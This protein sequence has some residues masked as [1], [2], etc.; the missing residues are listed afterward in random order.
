M[1]KRRTLIVVILVVMAL[2]VVGWG[3]THWRQRSPEREALVLYGSADI[4]EVQLAFRVSDRIADLRVEEGDTVHPGQTLATL[5]TSILQEEV[6]SAKASAE[7]QRQ[8]V[9]RLVH[10]SR[11]QEIDRA[12]GLVEETR[13]ILRDAQKLYT[14]TKEAFDQQ[15]GT[16]RELDD[17]VAGVQKAQGR[18]QA[19]KAELSLAVEGPRVE[20]IAAAKALLQEKQAAVDLAQTRLG[21][22][23][24]VAPAAGVIRER[25]LEPGDMA[26]P[27][28]P[29]LT[30]AK[31][32]P[33]WIRVYIDEPDLGVVRLGMNA[34]ITTDSFPDREFSGWVGYISPTAEFTPKVVHS[35][36]VRT[37][38]VYEAR[39]FVRN[40]AG[41]FRLG[42]PAT[43]SIPLDQ[44]PTD[45][46]NP[47]AP[48]E[49]S[50]GPESASPTPSPGSQPAPTTSEPKD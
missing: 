1:K 14:D 33:M 41:D 5:D 10:G 21:D 17:A 34:T 47:A 12:R 27:T 44:K 26:D 37:Q 15:A 46:A 20:D 13:A 9:D 25:I 48:T 36:H 4:R 3:V 38:L 45:H 24:L 42:M 43:V 6:N 40:P 28:R 16:Q 32:D 7:R 49:P 2:A 35:P 30:L 29:V 19:L 39:V 50:A 23:T 22:A 11:P 18:L 8:V 31:T